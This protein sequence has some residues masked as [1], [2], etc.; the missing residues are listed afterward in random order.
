M[1]FIKKLIGI[2][3]EP[4]YEPFDYMTVYTFSNL[5]TVDIWVQFGG[6][7]HHL[8][9]FSDPDLIELAVRRAEREGTPVRY[10]EY[11]RNPHY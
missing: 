10:V 5:D 9:M 8:G 3:S 6:Q 11:N 7:E 1:N 2:K 4:A